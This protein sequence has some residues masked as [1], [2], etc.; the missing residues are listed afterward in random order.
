MPEVGPAAGG[1]YA[2]EGVGS[3]LRRSSWGGNLTRWQPTTSRQTL[4]AFAIYLGVAMVYRGRF[5]LSAPGDGTLGRGPDVQIFIWGLQWWP[6]AL[7][8]GLDPLVSHVLWAPYGSDVLWTSTV[9]VLSL[10][11][12]PITLTLGPTVAWNLLVVLAPAA[13]GCAAY[14]LCRELTGRGWPSLVGGELYGF[15]SYQLAEGGVH[16]HVSMTV[17]VPLAALVVVR[18]VKGRLNTSG[19]AVRLGLIAAFQF[20]SSPELLA[21]MLVIGAVTLLAA[22]V[23]VPHARAELRRT[24]VAT[25][26]GLA[27][28][29]A[30]LAPVLVAMLR[31]TPGQALNPASEYS[32][33]LLNFIVPTRLTALGGAW[34]A[35]ISSQFTGNLAEQTAY[36]GLPLLAIVGCYLFAA[37]ASP[38]GRLLVVVLVTSV[39]LSLGPRLEVAGR[40]T[41]WLPE[42]LLSKVPMLAD[43]LPDRFALYTSLIVSV[44]VASWLADARGGLARWAVALLAV[45][46]LA[47]A[48]TASLWWAP[49]PHS[50]QR[51]DLGR[52]VPT[53]STVISLPFWRVDDRALYAQAVDRFRFGLVDRWVG[54]VPSQDRALARSSELASQRIGAGAIHAVLHELCAAHISYAVVRD[55]RAGRAQFLAALHVRPRHADDLLVYR[56]PCTTVAGS[57]VALQAPAHTRT[58]TKEPVPSRDGSDLERARAVRLAERPTGADFRARIRGPGSEQTNHRRS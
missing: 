17:M 44:I 26:M 43:A 46:S 47:P 18:Y 28:A 19:L 4:G 14:M 55:E 23:V 35:G 51:N 56:L 9:P 25:G 37:R 50:I 34:A 54:A 42:A 53:G 32:A 30:L 3:V 49:T 20:L 57:K 45:A 22:F 1:S 5:V 13:C 29:G 6:Y 58:H 36:V 52:L 39:V 15:S 38:S 24:I 48:A 16:L 21:T 7:S 31:E 11:A 40:A 8:H 2:V 12:A 27:G 41:L 33:D 10:L